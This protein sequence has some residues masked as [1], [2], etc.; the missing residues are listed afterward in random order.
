MVSKFNVNLLNSFLYSFI[1]Q[2]HRGR[3]I[4]NVLFFHVIVEQTNGADEIDG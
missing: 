2:Y 3:Y 4:N 1:W